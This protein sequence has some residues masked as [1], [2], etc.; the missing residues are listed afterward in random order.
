MEMIRA[1]GAKVLEVPFVKKGTSGGS[2][3]ARFYQR[4]A[5]DGRALDPH[6]PRGTSEDSRASLAS[7]G[8]TAAGCC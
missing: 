8:E 3:P 4:F 7:V 5:S 2:A 1:D 6:W